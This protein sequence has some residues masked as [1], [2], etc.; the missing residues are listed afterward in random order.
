MF[1]LTEIQNEGKHE[2]PFC[3]YQTLLFQILSLKICRKRIKIHKENG[4]Q[5]YQSMSVWQDKFFAASS[6]VCVYLK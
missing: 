3:N 5:K 4:Q 6:K 1:M 2:K